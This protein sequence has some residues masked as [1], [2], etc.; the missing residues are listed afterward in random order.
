MAVVQG[1]TS[2]AG[3]NWQFEFAG[4]GVGETSRPGMTMTLTK[5]RLKPDLQQLQREVEPTD[6]PVACPIAGLVD[7]TLLVNDG[8]LTIRPQGDE[9]RSCE[10]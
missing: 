2:D 4:A 7:H 3:S 8:V 6:N 10:N 9:I 1:L 5:K